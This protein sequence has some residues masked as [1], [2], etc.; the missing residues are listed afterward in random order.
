M[1]PGQPFF[2]RKPLRGMISSHAAG[3]Q[4]V[5]VKPPPPKKNFRLERGVMCCDDGFFLNQKLANISSQ[6]LNLF[7]LLL[8]YDL[9]R[10]FD[11][12][13]HTEQTE[14]QYAKRWSADSITTGRRLSGKGFLTVSPHVTGRVTHNASPSAEYSPEKKRKI[15]TLC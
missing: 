6:S 11:F 1:V 5:R 10:L 2:S 9:S 3:Q 12:I 15:R 14:S 7:N 13:C 8:L 4:L